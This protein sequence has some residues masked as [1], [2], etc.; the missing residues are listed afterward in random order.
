MPVS[1]ETSVMRIMD[2]R[3]NKEDESS[4]FGF[5][6]LESEQS[7][8]YL[9]VFI[10]PAEATALAL[11][12]EDAEMPRP[13]TYQL[14]TRLVDACGGRVNEVRITTLVDHVYVATVVLNTANGD[15]EIDARPSD[16]L[17]L[18]S[19]SGSPITAD[20]SLLLDLEDLTWLDDLL[21][22]A[23][24]VGE[25]RRRQD[26]AIQRLVRSPDESTDDA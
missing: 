8:R 16:A 15:Q 2:V 22:P 6:L 11:S 20:A 26:E 24:I 23:D 12:V 25:V 17:N 1:E 4:R 10:G 18:A 21:A 9:P 14:S 19:L 5:V 13:M 3:M 7:H